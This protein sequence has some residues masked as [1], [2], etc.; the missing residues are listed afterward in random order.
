MVLN[1]LYV[2]GNKALVNYNPGM[3]QQAMLLSYF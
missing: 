1:K 3:Y 2:K